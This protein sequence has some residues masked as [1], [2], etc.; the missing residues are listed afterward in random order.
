MERARKMMVFNL[1]TF[2]K[3]IRREKSE[4]PPTDRALTIREVGDKIGA[5]RSTIYRWIRE[6]NFPN[7]KRFG[8]CSIRWLES[9]V[10]AWMNS[11]EG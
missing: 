11:R 3:K 5:S 2:R 9:T 1:E 8:K 10:D 6:G 7:G 4:I